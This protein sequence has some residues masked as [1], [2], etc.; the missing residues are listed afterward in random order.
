MT[1]LT[2]GSIDMVDLSVD[3]AASLNGKP[4]F[5]VSRA[6]SDSDLMMPVCQSKPPFDKL[7]ARQALERVTQPAGQKK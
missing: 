7:A 5:A 2:A 1:A 3:N 6:L 4:G